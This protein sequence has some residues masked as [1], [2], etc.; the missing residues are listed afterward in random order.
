MNNFIEALEIKLE[1]S[2]V[3]FSEFDK[4]LWFY[5]CSR[6]KSELKKLTK[7]LGAKGKYFSDDNLG[8]IRLEVMRYLKIEFML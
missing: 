1:T 8:N 6:T 7:Q 4:G 5:L 3:T 2:E